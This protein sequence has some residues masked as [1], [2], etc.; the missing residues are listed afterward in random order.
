[1][2][3]VVPPIGKNRD[4]MTELDVADDIRRHF[5][6]FQEDVGF[7]LRVGLYCLT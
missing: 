3:S 4:R 7:N 1:M 2:R 6:R 5:P